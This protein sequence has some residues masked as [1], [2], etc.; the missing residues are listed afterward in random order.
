MK[1]ITMGSYGGP[2]VLVVDDVPMPEPADNEVRVRVHASSASRADAEMR[3]GGVARL[4]AGLFKP[5]APIPGAEFAGEIDKVG[6][7][8]SEFEKGDRVFGQTGISMGSYAEYVCIPA[9]EAIAR[10]PQDAGYEE[11]VA[12][13]EGMLTALAFLKDAAHV[14]EGQRVLVN[15]ASGAVG[16]AA[17]QVAK[18][19]GAHCTA[20]CGP[21]NVDLVTSLGADQVIDYAKQDFTQLDEAYDVIL[22]AVGKSTFSSCQRVLAPHGLYL[23][24]V[25][26]L[27]ILGSMVRTSL[28]GDKKAR[29]VFSGL[30]PTAEKLANL[31]LIN[32]LWRDGAIQPVIDRVFPLEKA[33]DAHR[34]IDAGHKRGN[35]VL[36]M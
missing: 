33:A 30:R 21:A 34:Y 16:S 25:P 10:M 7:A 20:V 11:A 3:K 18:Y 29:I 31:Q 32:E 26:S 14:H 2:E 19:L 35:V 24:T 36:A 12:L 23:T 22:D 13:V 15:G 17:V 6:A 8:V 5:K 27:G 4:A 28:F 9:E 1:A